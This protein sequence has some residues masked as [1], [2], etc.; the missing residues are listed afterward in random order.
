MEIPPNE[1][2]MPPE[3]AVAW[4]KFLSNE[5]RD[6]TDLPPPDAVFDDGWLFPLQ[7]RAELERMVGTAIENGAKTVLEVGTDKG[8]GFYSWMYRLQPKKAIAI[9]IRGVPFAEP[10]QRAFPKTKLLALEESSYAPGTVAKVA[11]FLGKDRLDVVFLDGDKANYHRDFEAYLPLVRPGGLI[12]LHDIVDDIEPRRF[13]WSLRSRFRLGVIIDGRE[14]ALAGL[15]TGPPTSAWNQWLR[16]WGANSCG[17]G[18][19]HV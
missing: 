8:G 17:V 12:F 4:E 13:F 9:E 16:I 15:E 1:Q 11:E 3:V 19:V 10:M 18:V 5:G 14:G 6:L 2:A 7:R